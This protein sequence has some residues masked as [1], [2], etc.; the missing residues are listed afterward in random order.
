[1][2]VVEY[3]VKQNASARLHLTVEE[4]NTRPVECEPAFHSLLLC[5]LTWREM[6]YQT[7]QYGA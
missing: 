6:P 5:V 7:P 2:A 4:C 3:K 1:M